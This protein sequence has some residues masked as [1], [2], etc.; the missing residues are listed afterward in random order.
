MNKHVELRID[1]NDE[2]LVIRIVAPGLFP[3]GEA[4][5]EAHVDDGVLVVHAPKRLRVSGFYPDAT[6]V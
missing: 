4:A 5:V 2:E 3:A 6:P 1:E